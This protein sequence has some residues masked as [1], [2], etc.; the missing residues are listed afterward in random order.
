M[1]YRIERN[2]TPWFDKMGPDDIRILLGV[3]NDMKYYVDSLERFYNSEVSGLSEQELKN[4][5]HLKKYDVRKY[6]KNSD[7][8][9]KALG[10]E[11]LF[12]TEEITEYTDEV[13]KGIIERYHFLMEKKEG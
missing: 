5:S 3:M 7:E 1:V 10:L 6:A 12:G 11:S 9:V 2:I 4:A 13:F 8:F